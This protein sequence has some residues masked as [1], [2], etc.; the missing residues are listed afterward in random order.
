MA[1]QPGE[2]YLVSVG[3]GDIDNITVRAH[4]ILERADIIFSLDFIHDKFAEL[5]AGKEFYNAGH[6][7][8][9]PTQFNK[10]KPGEESNYRRIIRKAVADGKVVAI[11]DFG[12]PTIYGPQAGYM[13]EFADLGIEVIPG[14]SSF[15]AANAALGVQLNGPQDF[16]VVLTHAI[17]D[18]PD[19]PD[20]FTPLASAQATMVFFTMRAD[21]PDLVK[22]LQV[23]YPPKTQVAV[24]SHAGDKARQA[25]LRGQLDTIVAQLEEIDLP[26][27]H[28]LYVGD[29]LLQAD[30]H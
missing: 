7:F 28:L 4:R 12:D 21:L 17:F 15:N 14:V 27:E 30:N 22:R 18:R 24:V 10:A 20:R 23:H 16:P 2:I 25:V 6:G 5:L 1:S 9:M 11:L 29:F 26:W 3:I 19:V 13:T 8:Y